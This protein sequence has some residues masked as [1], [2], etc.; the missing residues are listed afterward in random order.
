MA[1]GISKYIIPDYILKELCEQMS[2]SLPSSQTEEKNISENDETYLRIET[3]DVDGK[4]D[5]T[6]RGLCH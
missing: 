4:M 1:V 5:C 2:L 3:Q 6:A